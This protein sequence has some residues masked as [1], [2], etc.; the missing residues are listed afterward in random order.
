MA[1]IDQDRRNYLTAIWPSLNATRPMDPAL[2]TTDLAIKRGEHIEAALAQDSLRDRILFDPAWCPTL[3]DKLVA[4][5]DAL[6]ALDRQ[7]G[8]QTG[9]TAEYQTFRGERYNPHDPTDSS[10]LLKFLATAAFS[11]EQYVNEA[12]Q[13]QPP[14]PP[15]CSSVET[16]LDA[17][18]P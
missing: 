13:R 18:V 2:N 10:T 15:Y 3:H 5:L 14:T 1:D 4:E 11:C 8:D 9:L 6:H 12:R 17:G 7:G 16:M